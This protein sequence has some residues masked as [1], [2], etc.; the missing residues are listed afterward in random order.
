[1]LLG[2]AAYGEDP[3]EYEVL[4]VRDI[5]YI[6]DSDYADDKDTLDLY[7]PE[8]VGEFPV[9]LYIHGGGLLAGD[10]SSQARVGEWFARHGV[11]AAVVNYRL[12]PGVMYPAHI[13]DIAASF[14]WVHEHI[15]EHGGDQGKV[16]VAGHSAGAYLA[17][18]IALDERY[19]K[20]QGLSTEV[21]RG[22]VPISGFFHVERLAPGRPKSVWGTEKKDWRKASPARY[23][24][25][26]APPM[27]MIY[28]DG[29]VEE[30]KEESLDLAA[31]LREAGHTGVATLEIAD[32]THGSI[33]QRFG[34]EGDLT[35][36]RALEFMRGEL[37]DAR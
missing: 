23:V 29:D 32:R 21:I 9:V 13:E 2:A 30:R 31:K 27:L 10:K 6:A 34:E 36:I 8:G 25:M 26:N 7:L 18:L 15:E 1:M 28:A 16:F 33:A 37:D 3:E 17:G 20:A 35:S 14:A 4:V 11:G 19:L 22:V 24:S 12:S 5:D